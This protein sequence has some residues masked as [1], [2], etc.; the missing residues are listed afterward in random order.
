MNLFNS[1]IFICITLGGLGCGQKPPNTREA[2]EIGDSLSL[3]E[4]DLNALSSLN[5]KGP[6]AYD[7][8][9]NGRFY[10]IFGG[11]SGKNVRDFINERIQY[12]FKASDGYSLSPPDQ[13][14]IHR[15]W[16]YK[17][18]ESIDDTNVLAFNFGT[19]IWIQGLLDRTTYTVTLDKG[20]VVPATSSRV[21]IVGLTARYVKYLPK[22]DNSSTEIPI[23]FRQSTIIHEAR[24]SDCTDGITESDLNRIRQ[25]QSYSEFIHNSHARK[26][27]HFHSP[28]E[29]GDL[30][31]LLACD[32]DPWGSYGIQMI[33]LE[34][35]INNIK[36]GA[37]AWQILNAK[38]LDNKSRVQF[39]YLRMI[40]SQAHHPNM[41]SSG[42]R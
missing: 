25:A 28:C 1:T 34:G 36:P 40:Y 4:S 9:S 22:N 24:H 29:T 19:Q 7:A 2:A 3:L 11:Y 39:G 31:G 13:K 18:L 26:C 35:V 42:L 41:N 38:I 21:G 27:G 14:I 8:S 20:Q 6:R 33:F 12:Y 5:E 10:Q 15:N 30:K 16:I 17:G 32:L 37:A 23:E